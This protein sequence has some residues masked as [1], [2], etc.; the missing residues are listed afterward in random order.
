MRREERQGGHNQPF[1]GSDTSAVKAGVSEGE[2]P[3]CIEAANSPHAIDPEA[4]SEPAQDSKAAEDGKPSQLSKTAS[5]TKPAKR[6]KSK[7]ARSRQLPSFL[8]RVDLL[9]QGRQ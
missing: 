2:D 1:C 9:F 8:R 6:V 5:E 4:P 3:N 7:S